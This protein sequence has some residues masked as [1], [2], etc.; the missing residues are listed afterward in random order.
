MLFRRK[1]GLVLDARFKIVCASTR[2]RSYAR[3]RSWLPWT[4]PTPRASMFMHLCFSTS[5]SRLTGS[6]IPAK[7]H[8]A[9]AT[10]V[11]LGDGARFCP[12]S[13]TAGIAG[14]QQAVSAPSGVTLRAPAS[15]LNNEPSPFRHGGV[16][17]STRS[18]GAYHRGRRRQRLTAR[19]PR[20]CLRPAGRI[21]AHQKFRRWRDRRRVWSTAAKCLQPQADMLGVE[22]CPR[23]IITRVPYC[24]P[25][26]KR[27]RLGDCEA[28]LRRSFDNFLMIPD[29]S[30][31]AVPRRP[32]S[33]HHAGVE[34]HLTPRDYARS[35]VSGSR[36]R[37]ANVMPTAD[38]AEAG[39]LEVTVIS[40][41][42]RVNGK[43]QPAPSHSR[44]RPGVPFQR[45][46]VKGE[47]HWAVVER[48]T[49]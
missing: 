12:A 30:D 18:V 15:L 28:M 29:T 11:V 41:G 43:A 20:R 5:R 47:L 27:L 44:F 34:V 31:H 10:V 45:A 14:D 32:R 38:H 24:R 39:R 19:Y 3:G 13:S 7:A 26:R 22:G 9:A 17:V 37:Q 21:H 33:A 35:N 4:E 6:V 25:R 36:Q 40:E 16:G 23:A 8:G 2:R 1:I 49:T 46:G 42:R 48:L